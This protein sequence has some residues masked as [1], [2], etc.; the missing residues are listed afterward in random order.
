[1]RPVYELRRMLR[2][3]PKEPMDCVH[4]KVSPVDEDNCDGEWSCDSC[5][6]TQPFAVWRF[7]NA[8]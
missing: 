3:Y 2:G 7:W 4:I 1:M 6:E 8:G 5:G